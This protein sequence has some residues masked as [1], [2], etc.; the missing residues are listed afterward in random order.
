MK[1]AAVSVCSNGVIRPDATN[2]ASCASESSP[3]V[4]VAVTQRVAEAA[5]P[6]ITA[7]LA[8]LEVLGIAVC[9]HP[10]TAKSDRRHPS[11]RS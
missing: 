10:V 4:V 5:H 8:V 9:Q 3:P 1:V 2:R 6:R 7:C 11:M